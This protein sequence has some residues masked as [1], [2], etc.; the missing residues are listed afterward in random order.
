M[1]LWF[2]LFFKSVVLLNCQGF[3]HFK[4]FLVIL[5]HVLLNILLKNL[6]EKYECITRDSIFIDQLSKSEM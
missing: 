4:T 1:Q 5:V 3:V 6:L 2:C